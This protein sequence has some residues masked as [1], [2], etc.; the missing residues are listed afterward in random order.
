MIGFGQVSGLMRPRV[1]LAFV[2]VLSPSQ[3]SAE[4]A[5]YQGNDTWAFKH[6]INVANIFL[7][8]SYVWHKLR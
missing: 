5:L 4:Y 1:P 8:P 7:A 3:S 6:H 2:G